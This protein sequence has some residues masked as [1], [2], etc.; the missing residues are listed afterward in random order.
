M[1][2]EYVIKKN[3]KVIDSHVLNPMQAKGKSNSEVLAIAKKALADKLASK[4]QHRVTI[5]RGGE[6][7]GEWTC[8]PSKKK[9]VA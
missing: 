5:L 8:V 3:N 2:T 4:G 7:V 1:R 6:K 9:K